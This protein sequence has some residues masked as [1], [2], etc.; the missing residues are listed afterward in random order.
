MAVVNKSNLIGQSKKFYQSSDENKF[1][2]KNLL[3]ENL[4]V[5]A[6]V[7]NPIG[8]KLS[9]NLLSVIGPKMV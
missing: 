5:L 2:K 7:A 4:Y 9:A 1:L 8:T 3:A 6:I